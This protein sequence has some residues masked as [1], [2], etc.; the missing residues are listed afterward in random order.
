[1]KE[2]RFTAVFTANDQIAEA[3][4]RSFE[5]LNYRIPEDISLVTYDAENLN[6]K[7]KLNVTGVTQPFYEMGQCAARM[8]LN[9][10]DGNEDPYSYGQVCNSKLYRGVCEPDFIMTVI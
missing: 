5:N 8:L 9:L 2:M 7:I 1:M 6:R 10:I 3:A 4:I